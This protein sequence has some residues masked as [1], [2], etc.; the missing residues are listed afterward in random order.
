MAAVGMREFRAGLARYVEEGEPVQV[1]RHGQVVGVFVPTTPGQPFDREA[2][3]AA[4]ARVDA[5]LTDRGIDVDGL[6]EEF[7]ELRRRRR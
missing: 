6:A 3:L 1:T 5:A 2:L 4:G 7:D